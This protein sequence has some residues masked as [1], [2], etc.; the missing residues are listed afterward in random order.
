MKISKTNHVI[1]L[2]MQKHWQINIDFLEIFTIFDTPL[3]L[4]G[5]VG[6]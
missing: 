1:F 5:K 3:L 2:E 6:L 4:K